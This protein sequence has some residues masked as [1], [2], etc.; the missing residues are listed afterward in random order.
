MKSKILLFLSVIAA[1]FCWD[2]EAQI[3]DTNNEAVQTFA[4]SGFSGYVDGVGQLT[5]FNSIRTAEA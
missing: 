2:A 4:G 1:S 3:Y 5:M